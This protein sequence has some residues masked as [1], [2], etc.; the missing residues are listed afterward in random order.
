MWFIKNFHL[1]RFRP[2][3][4]FILFKYNQSNRIDVRIGDGTVKLATILTVRAMLISKKKYS[5]R[6]RNK[7]GGGGGGAMLPMPPAGDAPV[8]NSR[9]TSKELI[10]KIQKP[11]KQP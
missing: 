11:L 8:P 5:G 7:S 2:V 9:K 3:V 1:N 4:I 6:A 10:F